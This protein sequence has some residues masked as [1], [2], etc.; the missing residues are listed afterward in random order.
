MSE[1]ENFKIKI[2][3]KTTDKKKYFVL[4]EKNAY[5]LINVGLSKFQ[6]CQIFTIT[7]HNETF[8]PEDNLSSGSS[9]KYLY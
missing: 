3:N 7:N 1:V 9:N 2:D 6:N 8:Y 5:Y 4:H